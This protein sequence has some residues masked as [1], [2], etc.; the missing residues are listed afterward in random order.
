MYDF[1]EFPAAAFANVSYT[2]AEPANALY[3]TPQIN[4][5]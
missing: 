2:A 4:E 5:P 3:T 1:E